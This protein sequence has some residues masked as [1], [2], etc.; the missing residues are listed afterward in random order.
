FVV[1]SRSSLVATFLTETCAFGITAPD[2]SV[3]VP[4]TL[5]PVTWAQR[6]VGGSTTSSSA[7]NMKSAWANLFESILRTMALLLSSFPRSVGGVH[8]TGAMGLLDGG[9]FSRSYTCCQ[10]N[11]RNREQSEQQ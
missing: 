3:T 11:S 6:R 2:A 8:E 10:E 4:V 9:A 1:T 5:A 7:K